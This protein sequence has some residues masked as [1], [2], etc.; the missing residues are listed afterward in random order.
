MTEWFGEKT[1][2]V[3][4]AT[5]SAFG[6][7]ITSRY[8]KAHEMAEMLTFARLAAVK[9]FAHYVKE[10]YYDSKATL[11]TFELQSSV[12]DCDPVARQLHLLAKESISQFQWFDVVD[13][14]PEP[15]EED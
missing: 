6:I 8:G 14:G 9:D 15:Y 10:I 3:E 1:A 4:P 7:A 13:H 5:F 11:C 2:Q 12:K